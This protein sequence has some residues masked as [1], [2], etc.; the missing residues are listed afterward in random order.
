MCR[1]YYVLA[2]DTHDTHVYQYSM[3]YNWNIGQIFKLWLRFENNKYTVVNLNTFRLWIRFENNKYTVVNLNTFWLWILVSGLYPIDST[4]SCSR[5]GLLF[6]WTGEFSTLRSILISKIV[7]MVRLILRL[8]V[9]II[10]PIRRVNLI[11]SESDPIWS[12]MIWK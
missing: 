2:R 3:N 11:W 10:D 4:P 5:L 7:S 9:S 8:G 12:E 6:K 1:T